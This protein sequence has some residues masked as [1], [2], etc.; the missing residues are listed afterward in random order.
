MQGNAGKGKSLGSMLFPT[1][2]QHIVMTCSNTE[3]SSCQP[4]YRKIGERTA[5]A[6]QNATA[7]PPLSRAWSEQL[8]AAILLSENTQR[9]SAL[10]EGWRTEP[11]LLG[12]QLGGVGR[13]VGWRSEKVNKQR[14]PLAPVGRRRDFLVK[15]GRMRDCTEKPRENHTWFSSKKTLRSDLSYSSVSL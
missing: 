3:Q 12:L 8:L 14:I 11:S 10:S 7:S 9:S 15:G 13:L 4:G 5:P 6:L 2:L 1:I